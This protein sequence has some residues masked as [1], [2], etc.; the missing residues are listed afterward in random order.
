V[1]WSRE[2][3][4][5]TEEERKLQFLLLEKNG[6][7]KKKKNKKEGVEAMRLPACQA[8]HLWPF[9]CE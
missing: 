9:S 2:A 3:T 7:R 6:G 5:S 8:Q 4:L 1:D